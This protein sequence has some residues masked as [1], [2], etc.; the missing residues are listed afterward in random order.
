M[1]VLVDYPAAASPETQ[2]LIDRFHDSCRLI[3]EA[4]RDDLRRSRITLASRH[5]DALIAR[6]NAL[7]TLL[8]EGDRWLVLHPDEAD[9]DAWI[10]ADQEYRAIWDALRDGSRIAFGK[11]AAPEQARMWTE[12]VA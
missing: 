2:K 6:R 11:T 5:A 4:H 12:V 9:E 10:V 1:I 8:D 7:E 3:R